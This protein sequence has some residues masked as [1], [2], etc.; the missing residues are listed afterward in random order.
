MERAEILKYFITCIMFESLRLRHTAMPF[1]YFL[2]V[3]PAGPDLR[4]SNFAAGEE[5]LGYAYR[6]GGTRLPGK[7]KEK[8]MGMGLGE[9]K[10]GMAGKRWK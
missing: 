8:K 1:N 10:R 9:G 2:G 7:G 4:G 3:K 6:R 5:R